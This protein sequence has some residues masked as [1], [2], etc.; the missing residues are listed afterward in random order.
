MGPFPIGK[1]IHVREYSQ[2]SRGIPNSYKNNGL[3]NHFREQ[4]QDP[5]K[6]IF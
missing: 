5:V 6:N 4:E 3:D 1:K 2:E